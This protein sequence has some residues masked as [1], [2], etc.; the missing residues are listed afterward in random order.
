MGRKLLQTW[1]L[2]PLL[3]IREIE[4]RHDAVEMFSQTDNRFRAQQLRDSMKG[5]RNV[6]QACTRIRRGSGGPKDWR[7]LIEV[8]ERDVLGELSIDRP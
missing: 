3:D 5:I 2:R 8:S 1:H 4:A 7:D 6:A